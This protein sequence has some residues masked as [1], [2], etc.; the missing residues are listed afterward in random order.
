MD[1]DN[2]IVCIYMMICSNYELEKS[3]PKEKNKKITGL[4]KDE[5]GEKIVTE[6]IGLKTKVYCY[7]IDDPS[8]N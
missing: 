1:T 5:L 4:M 6:F 2:F 7:L 3:L 8:E